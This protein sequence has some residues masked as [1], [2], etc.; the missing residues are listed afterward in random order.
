MAA[1]T[2]WKDGQEKGTINKLFEGMRQSIQQIG[3]TTTIVA[4]KGPSW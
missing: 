4:H 1:H 3:E 2:L